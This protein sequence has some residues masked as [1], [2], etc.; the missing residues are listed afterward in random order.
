MRHAIA[1]DAAG[2]AILTTTSGS[3]LFTN[4]YLSLEIRQGTWWHAPVFGLRHRR[5]MKNT[6][7][8]AMLLQQDFEA[9]LQWLLDSQRAA[10][11]TVTMTRDVAADPHRIAGRVTVVGSDGEEIT[12]TKYIPVI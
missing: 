8:T 12:Y 1:I 5:R 2:T 4:V 9:A 10:T 11:V 6:A 7:T 3:P